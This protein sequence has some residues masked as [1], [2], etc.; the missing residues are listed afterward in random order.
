MYVTEHP[1]PLVI[2]QG[3]PEKTPAPLLE[4]LK[5]S[6]ITE[7]K[8]FEMVAV[9]VDKPET[10]AGVPQAT[11]EVDECLDTVREKEPVLCPFVESPE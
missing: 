4:K 9:H 1:D 6:P 7:P 5:V 3:V 11:E 10:S 2:V 8:T